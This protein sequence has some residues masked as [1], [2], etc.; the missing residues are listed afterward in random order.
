MYVVA[1]VTKLTYRGCKYLKQEEAV[2]NRQWWNM[3]HAAH[4]WLTYRGKR[5]R[6]CQTGGLI[7]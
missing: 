2:K 6:P 4:I 5:Y 7:Y 3:I 1:L